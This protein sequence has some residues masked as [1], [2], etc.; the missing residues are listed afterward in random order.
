MRASPTPTS[1]ARK[2]ARSTG[3]GRRPSSSARCAPSIPGRAR[4]STF[5][6]EQ[7]KVL[8]AALD[9]CRRRAGHGER[10]ARRLSRRGLRRRR[11]EAP[12]AAAA[13]QVGA[14]G[15][16][17]PARLCACRRA[18]CWPS[19]AV[20]SLPR[21]PA[22]TRAALQAH[23]RVRRRAVRRLA[24]PGQ[25][26]VDPG[27]PSRTPCSPSA[28][29]ACRCRARAA[30]TPAC[31]R[32]ARSRISTSRRRSAVDKCGRAQLPSQAATDRRHRGRDRAGRLPCPLLGDVPTLSLPHPEPPHAGGDRARPCLARAG[33]AR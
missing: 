8:G 14:G 7:I 27:A 20:V 9:P 29:S 1:S 12:E 16:R 25:R 30:P 2:K 15:R 11:P 17:L 33:A 22:L 4:R 21:P 3:G 6:G 32:W 23:H 19:P 28:A 24:A 13:G 31:M 5:N 26:P 10:R 18:R